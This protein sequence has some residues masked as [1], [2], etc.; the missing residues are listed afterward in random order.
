M[1]PSPPRLRPRYPPT[2]PLS[3]YAPAIRLPRYSPTPPAIRLSPPLSAYAPA[4]TCAVLSLGM[5][6]QGLH[7]REHRAA[8][9]KGIPYHCCCLAYRAAARASVRTGQSGAG[10]GSKHTRE[11]C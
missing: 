4:T 8:R 11:E 1:V 3:A 5:R 10:A 9:G 2:P 7:R 6:V